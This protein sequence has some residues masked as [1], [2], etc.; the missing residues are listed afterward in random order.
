L[1]LYNGYIYAS[2]H[3]HPVNCGD[4]IEDGN[5]FVDVADAEFEIAPGDESDIKVA[6]MYPWGS[7]WLV[8]GDGTAAATAL[9]IKHIPSLSGNCY[10]HSCFSVKKCHVE[11]QGRKEELGVSNEMAPKCDRMTAWMTFCCESV[12]E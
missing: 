4:V 11:Y 1:Q 7:E 10:F 12:L 5:R 8:F 2:A 9:A 3:L 6:N